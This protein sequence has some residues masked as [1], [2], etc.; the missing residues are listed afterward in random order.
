MKA[1]NGVSFTIEELERSPI[2]IYFTLFDQMEEQEKIRATRTLSYKEKRYLGSFV[3]PLTTILSG[4][5]FEGQ[6]RLNRPLVLQD[7]RVLKDEI[8]FMAE[9]GNLKKKHNN[10]GQEEDVVERQDEQIPTYL[11]L[12]ITLQ[13]LI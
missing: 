6:I 12:S 10:S 3:V 7:Y 13:P 1:K 2:M 4:S 11:Q 5:K 8:V 9:K